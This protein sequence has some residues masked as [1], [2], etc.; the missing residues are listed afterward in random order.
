MRSCIEGRS[1][2]GESLQADL[3]SSSSAFSRSVLS[4]PGSSSLSSSSSSSPTGSDPI[5][6]ATLGMLSRNNSP[7]SPSQRQSTLSSPTAV[8]VMGDPPDFRNTTSPGANAMTS[9]S[10]WLGGQAYAP[11]MTDRSRPFHHRWQRGE[12][13]LDIAA[14]AEPENS[15]AIVEQVEL[16]IAAAAHELLLAFGRAPGCG[17]IPAHQFGVSPQ[18]RAAYVPREGEVGIPV[19]AV[20]VIVENAADPSHLLTVL[21]VEIFVA[22]TFAF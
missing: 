17:E 5:I 10:S 7:S 4:S 2:D 13:R 15:A 8:T 20:D 22:P 18:E 9:S 6:S 3:A 21:Q 16:H 12:D 14:S 1:A 19:S 11:S